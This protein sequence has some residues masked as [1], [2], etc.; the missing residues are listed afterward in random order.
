MARSTPAQTG[1]TCSLNCHCKNVRQVSL[2]QSGRRSAGPMHVVPLVPGSGLQLRRQP[3]RTGA[4]SRQPAACRSSSGGGRSYS[5]ICP[6]SAPKRAPAAARVEVASQRS[7]LLP[8]SH[9]VVL[10]AALVS[11]GKRSDK[12]L[13]VFNIFRGRSK[14][15]AE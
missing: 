5:H 2:R 8:L 7:F 14:S 13:P 3:C 10:N 15:P 4:P 12:S 11:R 6:C 1:G 9:L